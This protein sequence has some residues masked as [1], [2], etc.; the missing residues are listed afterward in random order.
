MALIRWDP[1]REM[2]GIREGIRRVFED[3]LVRMRKEKAEGSGADW[4]P[5]RRHLS[6][7]GRLHPDHGSASE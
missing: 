5:G 2:E 7:S 6:R 4:S 1:V 3:S